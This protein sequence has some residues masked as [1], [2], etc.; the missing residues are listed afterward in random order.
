MTKVVDKGVREG[1]GPNAEQRF[2]AAAAAVAAVAVAAAALDDSMPVVSCTVPAPSIVVVFVAVY[3]YSSGGIVGEDA[4][5][6]A[7]VE[8]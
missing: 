2:I 7:V 6:V 4:V 8:E 1:C 3:P 5:G